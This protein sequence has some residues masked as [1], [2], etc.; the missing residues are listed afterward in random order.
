MSTEQ[1]EAE[2][3]AAAEAQADADAQAAAEAGAGDDEEE[4]TVKKSEFEKIKSDRDN[5]R[6]ATLIKKA[7]ERAGKMN[8]EEKKE[9][10]SATIDEARVA[11]IAK[12][13]IS[14]VREETYESNQ[15]RA[16]RVFLQ[17][18]PEYVD[19]AQWV[20]LMSNVSPRR[21]KS[22]PEDIMED[23]ED[24]ILLHKKSTGKLDEYFKSE[25]ERAIRDSQ[26]DNQFGLA[27]SAGG[28][29][30]RNEVPKSASTL[31]PKGEEMARGMHVDIEKV[32]KI[33]PSKDNVIQ[34][35]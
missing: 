8:E 15:K 17:K 1:E 32:K 10:F 9:E 35:R 3:R 26:I 30:D 31:T 7:D 23:L 34:I 13:Q 28:I 33:D 6:A 29:G 14:A 20:Q 2:A 19:D 22:T 18:H 25:A 27:R 5:Y 4:I 21:G 16:N 24:G 11:E 12:A